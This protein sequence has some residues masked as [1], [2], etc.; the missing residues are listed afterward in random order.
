MTGE[1]RMGG[2]SNGHVTRR[3]HDVSGDGS[4]GSIV[5]GGGG[6][7]G[8]DVTANVT[9]PGENVMVGGGSLLYRI[10]NYTLMPIFLMLFSANIS[11]VLWHA[12]AKHDGSL[13]AEYRSLAREGVV[14]GLCRMWREIDVLSP[15]SCAVVAGYSVYAVILMK[16]LPGPTV[17]GPLTPKGNRPVYKNNGFSC[18]VVTMLTFAGLQY[19]LQTHY[20]LSATV[21]YDRF[22]ELLVTLTVFSHLLCVVLYVKGL[23]WP[24]TSDHG[25][26]GNPVFDYYWGTELYPSLL[27]VDVKVFTNCR[28]GMTVWP[29]LVAIHALKSYELHGFVDSM[30]VSCAL[31]MVYFAKFFWWEAGYMR[32]IDIMVDRAG[33][34]ICWG[35]LTFIPGV[36]ASVSMYL[37]SHP[38][39][40]GPYLSAALV[41]VGLGAVAVNYWADWQKLYVRDT[42]GQCTIWGRKPELIRA[43]YKLETGE[44]RQSLLLLSGFWGVARHFHYVPEL[45]LALCWTLPALFHHLAPYCYL[46]ILTCILVHRTYRDDNKC[47][48]KYGDYWTQYCQKVPYKMIPGLF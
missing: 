36:Y 9:P 12:S 41:V 37:V 2:T 5:N 47:S 15:F 43:N 7:D 26:S 44:S 13:L 16:L 6:G 42:D 8:A 28:F 11:L 10:V 45:T 27:G 1:R 22:D 39:R 31:Q 19:V 14:S 30:W 3:R 38:V 20:Q 34:Y 4:N 33:F 32:T 25:S 40:L 48:A 24:S 35:C 46:I 18:F 21:V 17:Y 29:L 23:R